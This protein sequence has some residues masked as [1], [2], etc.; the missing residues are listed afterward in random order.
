VVL[1]SASPSRKMLL[2]Q[3]GVDFEVVVSGVDE[4]VPPEFTPAQTVETLAQRK[5]EAV[6]ALRPEMPIIAADSVVSIDGLILGKPADDQAAKATLRRLSGRTHQLITGWLL[7]A[8]KQHTRHFPP[9][10]G[11]DTARNRG[12]PA[13]ASG[14]GGAGPSIQGIIRIG[15]CPPE[16]PL[17]KL[18][19]VTAPEQARPRRNVVVQRF[20]V[21]TQK[22]R[23]EVSLLAAA[24]FTGAPPRR[25]GP[26]LHLGGSP[27]RPPGLC[28]TMNQC[29]GG[30]A[31]P[32]PFVTIERM[33]GEPVAVQ[34]HRT[35]SCA[36][37]CWA[38]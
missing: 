36:S 7:A 27:K 13:P 18:R 22:K 24:L 1:A 11:G 17:G 9:R 26:G 29:G 5:G 2:E 28:A 3:A 21:P 16:I 6:L 8:G 33:V 23:G 25:V 34:R 14:H 32:R 10:G 30:P 35:S 20:A 19:S 37:R 4:T 38:R 15:A 31:Q 12:A